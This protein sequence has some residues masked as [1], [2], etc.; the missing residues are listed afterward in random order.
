MYRHSGMDTTN[1][2]RSVVLGMGDGSMTT[3]T[4]ADPAKDGTKVVIT[5]NYEEYAARS[6]NET[7]WWARVCPV[8]VRH[9][10]A[11]VAQFVIL[12]DVRDGIFKL[13]RAQ[14][15]ILRK[16]CSKIPILGSFESCRGKQLS[17]PSPYLATYLSNIMNF[18]R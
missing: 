7:L 18:R 8:H 6:L 2:G 9:S 13:L 15:S 16:D 17:Y 1:D 11:Y 4:I 5:C 10:F 3:L 12:R 14:E